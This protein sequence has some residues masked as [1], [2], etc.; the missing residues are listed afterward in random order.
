MGPVHK[1]IEQAKE[2]AFL[3]VLI[4]VIVS[5]KEHWSDQFFGSDSK[6]STA[7][8]LLLP[9]SVCGAFCEAVAFMYINRLGI[10]CC[11]LDEDGNPGEPFTGTPNVEDE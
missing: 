4:K 6:G 10:N 9:K 3:H 7:F 5:G 1:T 11:L 8:L 2:A